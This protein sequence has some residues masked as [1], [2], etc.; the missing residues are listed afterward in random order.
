MLYFFINFLIWYK[1]CWRNQALAR[2]KLSLYSLLS[3]MS[4]FKGQQ[5]EFCLSKYLNACQPQQRHQGF[6][7]ILEVI[8]S[9][10]L[11]CQTELQLCIRKVMKPLIQVFLW[12]EPW[13]SEFLWVLFGKEAKS[14]KFN[15]QVIKRVLEMSFD[16]W[17]QCA[18]EHFSMCVWGFLVQLS[19]FVLYA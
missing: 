3:L 7:F 6:F 5:F 13:N 11:C 17:K 15:S 16:L 1:Y 18:G 12:H 19:Q 4:C 14:G 8:Y 2:C 10:W 9:W